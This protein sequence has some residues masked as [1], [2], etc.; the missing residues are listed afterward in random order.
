[1]HSISRLTMRRHRSPKV[2]EIKTRIKDLFKQLDKLAEARSEEPSKTGEDE[3]GEKK[4]QPAE[5]ERLR[6]E[7]SDI[8]K[9]I[10]AEYLLLSEAYKEEEEEEEEESRRHLQM[11][12]QY[13]EYD[14]STK[15]GDFARDN[16]LS[17]LRKALDKWYQSGMGKSSDTRVFDKLLDE[18]GIKGYVMGHEV[19]GPEEGGN[20][21]D[22]SVREILKY[23]IDL[24]NLLGED[25]ATKYFYD[26]VDRTRLSFKEAGKETGYSP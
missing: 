3:S 1:M 11:E 24:K 22:G 18:M 8:E 9:K 4:K 5:F 14:A 16:A 21:K 15:F 10:S 17:G 6:D 25:H 7:I 19:A 26:E 13:T 2:A 12:H 23:F 20:T